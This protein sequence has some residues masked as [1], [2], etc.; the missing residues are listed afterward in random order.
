LFCV[1][2]CC[3]GNLQPSPNHL[4]R[5]KWAARRGGEGNVK[6]GGGIEG[7]A[8]MAMGWVGVDLYFS[9]FHVF[10]NTTN[11]GG[12][13]IPLTSPTPIF[14]GH[15]P[16]SLRESPPILA[17]FQF[18][19]CYDLPTSP[20]ALGDRC[21]CVYMSSQ[22]QNGMRQT[23]RRTDAMWQHIKGESVRRHYVIDVHDEGPG[24]RWKLSIRKLTLNELY[25]L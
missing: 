18:K 10:T 9:L 7:R 24:A 15:V 16:P 13:A 11:F 3:W 14:G 25:S 20:S 23:S 21:Q 6:R 2:G 5:F 17:Q 8:D 12:G 1:C 22:L 4:A 19:L